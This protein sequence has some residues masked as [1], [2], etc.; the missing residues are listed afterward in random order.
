MEF[1]YKGVC[2]C[3]MTTPFNTAWA[4]L[5]NEPYPLTPQEEKTLQMQNQAYEMA[6]SKNPQPPNMTNERYDELIQESGERILAGMMAQSKPDYPWPKKGFFQTTFLDR[7]NLSFDPML[8]QQRRQ[9]ARIARESNR[10]EAV[11]SQI[12][13]DPDPRSSVIRN[14]SV[15]IL[16]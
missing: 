3:A 15:K 9:N 6:R 7:G 13:I 11:P 1:L 12:Q 4:L 8:T 14:F 5:K 16:S 2:G 10:R